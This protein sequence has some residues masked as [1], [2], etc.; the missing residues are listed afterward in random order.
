MELF[1]GFWGVE[2]I[3]VLETFEK[4]VTRFQKMG[5]NWKI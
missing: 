4:E 5:Q 1:R 2:E 3:F